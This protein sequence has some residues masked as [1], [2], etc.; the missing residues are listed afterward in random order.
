MKYNPSNFFKQV[1]NSMAE[2]K[3]SDIHSSGKKE[4]YRFFGLAI[5]LAIW[6][7]SELFVHCVFTCVIRKPFKGDN[8]TH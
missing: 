2:S 6:R 4:S 8:L 3:K 7:I 1:V 5:E